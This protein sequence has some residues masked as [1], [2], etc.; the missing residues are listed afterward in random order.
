MR[1]STDRRLW[2]ST[3][4]ISKRGRRAAGGQQRRG[5]QWASPQ[6]SGCRSQQTQIPQ[7]EPGQPRWATAFQIWGSQARRNP[8]A[9]HLWPSW[10]GWAS[11]LNTP[12]LS[13]ITWLI[14]DLFL[15]E[16]KEEKN[17]LYFL[18][19]CYIF[20]LTWVW[21]DLVTLKPALTHCLQYSA[22]TVFTSFSENLRKKWFPV[23]FWKKLQR[24]KNQIYIRA[25]DE[26]R[27]WLFV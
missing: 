14:L 23:F 3:T 17:L 12:A 21:P 20:V 16:R 7:P 9:P 25:K 26:V 22:V 13:P 2:H 5:R 10:G 8:T 18:L 19:C 27:L 11:E 1:R 6:A 24:I 4:D 15:L